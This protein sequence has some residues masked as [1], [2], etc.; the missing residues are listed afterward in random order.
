MK[1]IPYMM[2]TSPGGVLQIG[3]WVENCVEHRI[4]MEKVL[5]E[6]NEV[7]L[8]SKEWIQDHYPVSM[9]QDRDKEKWEQYLFHPL[10]N[11]QLWYCNDCHAVW[12][13]GFKGVWVKSDW[14]GDIERRFDQPHPISTEMKLQRS[15]PPYPGATK[16]PHCHTWREVLTTEVIGNGIDRQ[17]K[18]TVWCVKCQGSDVIVKSQ[19]S[20][21]IPENSILERVSLEDLV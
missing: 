17:I 19:P 20:D 8:A 14:Q 12:G 9:I 21:V 18:Q 13:V 15:T 2:Q 6:Q 4:P 11:G 3:E 16:C 5:P 10:M 7:V 1:F